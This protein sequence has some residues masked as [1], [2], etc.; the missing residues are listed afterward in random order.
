MSWNLAEI[1]LGTWVTIPHR[2]KNQIPNY[3]LARSIISNLLSFDKF[4]KNFQQ[5]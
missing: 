5:N 4:V 3:K 2:Q 1:V